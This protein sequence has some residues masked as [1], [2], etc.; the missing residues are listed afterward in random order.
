MA[1]FLLS[2]AL[3]YGPAMPNLP[4]EGNGALL[5]S[6]LC[7]CLGAE[8]KGSDSRAAPARRELCTA[9]EMN[10][11][12]GFLQ[13]STLRCALSTGLLIYAKC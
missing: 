8:P 3:S 11:S 6:A 5:S 4:E 7:S 13:M 12:I 10:T 1:A 2:C 9:T